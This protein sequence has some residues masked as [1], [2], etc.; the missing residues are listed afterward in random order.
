MELPHSRVL[1]NCNYATNEID[2][3]KEL[4]D[5]Y[6]SC[7]EG[8]QKL[9]CHK[10][11]LKKNNNLF[12][13]L[14]ADINNSC[15]SDSFTIIE[16]VIKDLYDMYFWDIDRNKN[17]YPEIIYRRPEYINVIGGIYKD[18]SNNFDIDHLNAIFHY[19]HILDNYNPNNSDNR[20]GLLEFLLYIFK[21][22][23]VEELLNFA[24][25]SF[26]ERYFNFE[27]R[28]YTNRSVSINFEKNYT[29]VLNVSSISNNYLFNGPNNSIAYS[30][31]NI[32]TGFKTSYHLTNEDMDNND[33]DI[34]LL[35]DV[36]NITNKIIYLNG[37]PVLIEFNDNYKT[38][39]EHKINI[40]FKIFPIIKHSFNIFYIKFYYLILKNIDKIKLDSIIYNPNY[41]WFSI[42][43][44]YLIIKN[45]SLI[46]GY[47]QNSIRILIENIAKEYN[48]D[49]QGDLEYYFEKRYCNKTAIFKKPIGFY[50]NFIE[51]FNLKYYDEFVNQSLDVNFNSIT[52]KNIINNQS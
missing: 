46:N 40:N 47:N 38:F 29:S 33:F 26:N 10:I 27:F 31:N 6:V 3:N 28:D 52:V 49:Y 48:P 18:Y 36:R 20:N 30:N 9:Y 51:N 41:K 5:F 8:Y 1:I 11:I 50:E 2:A 25:N 39:E 32:I 14:R 22:K 23:D 37:S 45:N 34:D 21:D 4:C 12:L 7:P 19:A 42:I 35:S 43:K 13:M 17:I 15:I 44:S 24:N 16:I